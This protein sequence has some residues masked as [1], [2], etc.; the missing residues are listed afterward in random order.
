[1][2]LLTDTAATKALEDMPAYKD[3]LQ[4]FTTR[5]AGRP[6]PALPQRT[7]RVVCAAASCEPA[8]RL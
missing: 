8:C 1:M 4:A 5:E 2:T 7:R 3:L 6:R